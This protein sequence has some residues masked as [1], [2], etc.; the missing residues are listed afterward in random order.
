MAN[1]FKP[2]VR[3]HGIPAVDRAQSA[4]IRSSDGKLRPGHTLTR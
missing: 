4:T 1:K 2:V 3:V